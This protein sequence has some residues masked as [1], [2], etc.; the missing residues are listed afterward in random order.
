M[1]LARYISVVTVAVM[2]VAGTALILGG[3]YPRAVASAAFGTAVAYINAVAAYAIMVWAR[4]RPVNV[5]LGAIL[6]GTLGRMVAMLAGLILGVRALSLAALPLA[7]ALIVYFA[8]FLV[9]EV[10]VLPKRVAAEV[11]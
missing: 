3:E 9:L 4:Q 1:T 7:G 11:R 2:P 10:S 5:F 6:G 8:L